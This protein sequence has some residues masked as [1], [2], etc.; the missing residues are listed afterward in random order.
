VDPAESLQFQDFRSVSVA[1]DDTNVYLLLEV[2]A[3]VMTGGFGAGYWTVLDTDMNRETGYTGEL[4]RPFSIGGDFAILGGGYT[5]TVYPWNTDGC[6]VGAALPDA[7]VGYSDG[8]KVEVSIP[9]ADLGLTSPLSKFRIQCVAWKSY[10]YL[11]EGGDTG[12][13]YLYEFTRCIPPYADT[14]GDHDVDQEDFGVLQKC[15]TGA[16]HDGGL[17]LPC[18]CF[19]LQGGAPDGS[20]DLADYA[21]FLNCWSGP[22]VASPCQ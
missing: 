3:L 21:A 19:D 5:V 1:H 16:L 6:T 14:D 13:A 22:K 20:I 17:T 4:Q 7:H 10:D 2:N 12:N 11:P 15:F 18:L 9:R 8:M